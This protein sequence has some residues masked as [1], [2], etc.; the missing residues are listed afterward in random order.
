MIKSYKLYVGVV[1]GAGLAVAG[2]AF[3]V[4][5]VFQTGQPISSEAVN[6]NFG[7][8]QT[9]VNELRAL[10]EAAQQQG[11][12]RRVCGATT[13]T[14]TGDIGGFAGVEAQCRVVCGTG[15]RMCTGTEVLQH[16]SDLL[17]LPALGG[18]GNGRDASCAASGSGYWV[19]SAPYVVQGPNID[20]NGRPMSLVNC[21][22][23]TEGV[24]R[25][26]GASTAICRGSRGLEMGAEWCSSRFPILCCK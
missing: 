21:S 19:G 6:T 12:V 20:S 24:E 18:V 10:V 1:I 2:A 7:A 9:E 14:F 22:N 26:A 5:N 3:G 4:P 8:L 15:A 25:A 13:T 23:W 11:R 17:P 16:Q